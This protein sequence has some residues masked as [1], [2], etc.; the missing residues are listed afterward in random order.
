MELAS[1]LI[2]LLGVN[3]LH[4]RFMICTYLFQAAT[5]QPSFAIA[6]VKI[7]FYDNL[8]NS[9]KFPNERKTYGFI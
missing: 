6:K 1:I 9:I 8:L 3:I 2:I 5:T 4:A 7:L